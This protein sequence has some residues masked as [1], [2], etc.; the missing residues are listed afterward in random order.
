MDYVGR[1]S[2]V[3]L[4]AGKAWKE[5]LKGASRVMLDKARLT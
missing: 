4:M 5:S 2:D 1:A 3:W